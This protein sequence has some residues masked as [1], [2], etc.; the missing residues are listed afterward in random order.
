MTMVTTVKAMLPDWEEMALAAE[1]MRTNTTKVL[2]LNLTTSESKFKR[3][4]S[5]TRRT[6]ETKRRD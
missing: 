3:K 6:R 5:P 2:H 4:R 1:K